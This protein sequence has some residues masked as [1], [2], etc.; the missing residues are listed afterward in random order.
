MNIKKTLQKIDQFLKWIS[1]IN[2]K[3]Y[4]AK[5]N[6]Q[7]KSKIMTK[8]N[9]IF[10]ILQQN[11]KKSYDVMIQLFENIKTKK[12]D[13]IIIQKLWRKNDCNITYHSNKNHFEFLY[14]NHEIT[15]IYYYINKKLIMNFWN[16]INYISNF[17]ILHFKIIDEKIIYIYNIYNFD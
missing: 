9:E 12:Y 4:I 8:H 14:L 17:N 11:T 7:S 2:K 15:K 10:K 13:I 5:Y 16:F 3:K 6:I 1:T